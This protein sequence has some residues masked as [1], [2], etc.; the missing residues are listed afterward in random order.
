MT[1]VFQRPRPPGSTRSEMTG[2]NGFVLIAALWLIVAFSAVSV[3]YGTRS[4]TQRL[5]AANRIDEAR[6][7]AA[8]ESAI[9]HARSRVFAVHR[10]GAIRSRG[11][12]LQRILAHDRIARLLQDTFS[13]GTAHYT[14]RIFDAGARLNINTADEEQL[15]R[16]LGAFRVDWSDADHIAQ[17]VADWRDGDDLYRARGAEREHYLGARLPGIPTNAPFESVHE[18]SYVMG[19]T[20]E[21]FDAIAPHLTLEGPGL[22]NVNTA[23]E[24]VL[25]PLPGMSAG[26]IELVLRRR[27]Q[28]QWI[29]T[30]QELSDALSPIARQ[31]FLPAM[32][33]F[34]RRATFDVVELLAV[35]EGWVEG[36]PVR[37][38]VTAQLIPAGSIVLVP[39]RRYE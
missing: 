22:V 4:R 8:A 39:W 31:A 37:V 28:G 26:A 14:V 2:R 38:R 5:S 27:R 9:E 20:P 33:E 6:A 34:L 12:E 13:L 21:I 30:A 18:M 11:I 23:P 29:R 24:P 25:L 35:G 19:M 10:E 36:S 17:S 7:R 1:Q 15:R 32:P 3:H 16:F